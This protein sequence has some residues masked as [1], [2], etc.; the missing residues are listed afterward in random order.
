MGQGSSVGESI[1]ATGGAD[2]ILKI[3][4]HDLD[5]GAE[6]IPPAFQV[7][8]DLDHSGEQIYA[9]ESFRTG[10]SPLRLLSAA[11]SVLYLWDLGSGRAFSE[12]V[13]FQGDLRGRSDPFGGPRNPDNQTFIFDAKP[14]IDKASAMYGC[15]AAA[16]SDG[17]NIKTCSCSDHL[18]LSYCYVN[19]P[20]T[21]RFRDFRSA[22]D[23]LSVDM[24]GQSGSSGGSHGSVAPLGSVLKSLRRGQGGGDAAPVIAS[25]GDGIYDAKILTLDQK[26]F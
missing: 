14:S 2:G 10:T 16:L 3:W 11:G 8:C 13:S 20:G 7:V 9:C 21:I 24:T 17:A 18:F 1:I 4:S 26:S 12:R 5:S 25:E 15:A 23:A 22:S 6:G 19:V